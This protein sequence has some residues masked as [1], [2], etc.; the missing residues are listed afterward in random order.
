MK[1][2]NLK[3]RRGRA[4]ERKVKGEQKRE[5]GERE[6]ESDRNTCTSYATCLGKLQNVFEDELKEKRIEIEN[7]KLVTDKSGTMSGRG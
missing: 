4:R 6:K 2:C 7:G 3:K 5:K 1:M